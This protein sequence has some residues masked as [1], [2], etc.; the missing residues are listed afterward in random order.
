MIFINLNKPT[1]CILLS[2]I[3]LFNPSLFKTLAIVRV[4]TFRCP[5][6]SVS[7]FV[8]VLV[9][10]V[11][12]I[13]KPKHTANAL[14]CVLC[15]LTYVFR[16][17]SRMR[18]FLR[19]NCQSLAVNLRFKCVLIFA[20]RYHISNW[21]TYKKLSTLH[22]IIVIR[23][24]RVSKYGEWRLLEGENVFTAI[25]WKVCDFNDRRNLRSETRGIF[26]W[27]IRWADI[28]WKPAK[29]LLPVMIQ[30]ISFHS[31]DIVCIIPV[32]RLFAQYF[33]S[34]FVGSWRI[35]LNSWKLLLFRLT[36]TPKELDY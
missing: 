9:W 32:N 12:W 14:Y 35:L 1:Y 4:K 31:K 18:P 13:D 15:M 5:C 3:P 24:E 11:W 25:S 28:R 29:T 8:F 20:Y 10:I 33:W 23:H 21:S 30:S 16:F 22:V 26:Q 34:T 6:I 7:D 2:Y 27:S 19:L 36:I 17:P